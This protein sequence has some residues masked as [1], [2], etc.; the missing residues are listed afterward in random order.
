MKCTT[1]NH[2]IIHISNII[3]IASSSTEQAR[4]R[5]EGKP[6]SDR[7]R[8]KTSGARTKNTVSR[9]MCLIRELSLL[10]LYCKYIHVRLRAN[11]PHECRDFF[12][13]RA[14]ATW[15]FKVR[16]ILAL[17]DIHILY[18]SILRCKQDVTPACRVRRISMRK[19]CLAQIMLLFYIYSSQNTIK[20]RF[21][22]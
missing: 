6:T 7:A 19:L 1:L 5:S 2:T 4:G 3:C 22:A 8:L 21:V 10:H 20:E 16:D 18:G 17:L 12:Y 15:L 9:N 14:R 11:K 13:L